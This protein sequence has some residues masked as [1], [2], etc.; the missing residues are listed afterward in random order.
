MHSFQTIFSPFLGRYNS[1]SLK[2]SP[3]KPCTFSLSIQNSWIMIFTLSILCMFEQLEKMY[4]LSNDSVDYLG[5]HTHSI[6]INF[7]K[8]ERAID[9]SYNI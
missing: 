6:I 9:N 1:T 5:L 8:W 3:I 4:Q 2:F 7:A